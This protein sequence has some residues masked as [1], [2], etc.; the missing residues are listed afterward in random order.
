MFTYEDDHSTSNIKCSNLAASCGGVQRNFTEETHET[1]QTGSSS[2]AEETVSTSPTSETTEDHETET[3]SSTS[4]H[5]HE[6][7]RTTEDYETDI[8]RTDQDHASEKTTE[9]YETGTFSSASATDTTDQDHETETYLD[10]SETEYH[11][12]ETTSAVSDSNRIEDPEHGSGS[13]PAEILEFTADPGASSVG[14][15][16]EHCPHSAPFIGA[17]CSPE[18]MDLTCHY[19]KQRCCDKDHFALR[20]SCTKHKTWLTVVVD[21][22]CDLGDSRF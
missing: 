9:D 22:G 8:T 2:V 4:E 15:N 19:K 10:G 5:E 18:E 11:D 17:E 21:S 3:S 12:S 7:E 16:D 1:E 13:E 20:S 14:D 6:T